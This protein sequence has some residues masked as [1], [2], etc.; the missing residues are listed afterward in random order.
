MVTRIV[1]FKEEGRFE[2][3]RYYCDDQEIATE[4]YDKNGILL[5]GTGIIPN[6]IVREYYRIG[7]IKKEIMF[8]DGRAHGRGIDYYP[9]GEI[10]E[11]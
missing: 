2:Q 4:L 1:S 8:K 10:F 3:I 6:G 11:K 9:S 7:V 5:H